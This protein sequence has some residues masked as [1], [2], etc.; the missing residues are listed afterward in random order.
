MFAQDEWRATTNLTLSY[1]FRWDW[2][3]APFEPNGTASG[4][5]PAIANPRAGGRLGA[6]EF[7][8][9]GDGRTGE[10]SLSNNWYEGFA[11]RLGVA[12]QLTPKTVIRGS[13][14]LYY[15]PGF[16]TR[17]VAYGFN[18]SASIPSPNGYAPIYNWSASGF[19]QDF[20][21]A[22]FIDPSFQN[23]QNVSSILDGTSRMP[24]I[25][26]WTFSVQRE[27]ASNLAFEASYIGSKSTH[28]ILSGA[29]SNMNVLD[30]SYLSLGNLLLQDIN[31]T[32]AAAAGIF[33]PYPN[34]SAQRNRTVGQA[35]RPYPQYLNVN[36]EWGPHGVARYHSLQLKLNKRYSSGLTFLTFYTW[37]K[38]MTNVEGGP[39][40]LGP[41]DGAI[42]YPRN[43]A[44]EVSISTE[45]PPSVF[46]AS[47]SYELPF[48]PGKPFL[49]SNKALGYLVGGWQITGYVRY[50]SGAPLAVTSTNPLASFGFPNIRANYVEGSGFLVTNP[51]EF[52]PARDRYLDR[53][54]FAAPSTFQLGNTARVLDWLRGFTQKSEA[55]SVAKR[56]P[57]TERVRAI[58]RADAQNPFNFVRWNNPNTTI[59]SADFGRVT[60]AAGG[61]S[62][63]LNATL[64]F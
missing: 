5:N 59:T 24:Q 7:A 15:A 48:G 14:G 58:V 9:E 2:N 36:E 29:Q 46:V 64:E 30:A 13:G 25:V 43:R 33:S 16:R 37:S 44:G 26:S 27:L 19:P 4:F 18:S 32:G 23:D 61:R 17:M 28:L 47:S 31:S 38:N 62:M 8:G 22:P 10:R 35:L 56:I 53:T 3:G 40:D 20:P 57:I 42:Q 60:G 21:R 41:G 6:L 63:Q 52:D 45:G 12:Y 55:I 54:A 51:R 49:G 39:I 50:A 1:G 11:P 34:F